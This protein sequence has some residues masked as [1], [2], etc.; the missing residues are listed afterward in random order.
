MKINENK[1][2]F[3]KSTT[4]E[5]FFA[6]FDSKFCRFI[7]LWMDTATVNPCVYKKKYKNTK[8]QGVD[9]DSHHQED[10]VDKIITD[11]VKMKM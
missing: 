9:H 6:Q 2:I 3:M 10:Y 1:I 7:Q 5:R 11:T 8:K 4:L